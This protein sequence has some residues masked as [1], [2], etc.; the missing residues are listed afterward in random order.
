MTS[1][2]QHPP[3]S[4]LMEQWHRDIS[5]LLDRTSEASRPG[6]S[7]DAAWAPDVDLQDRVPEQ[8]LVAAKPIP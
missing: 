2:A 4:S 1:P 8:S 3:W 5:Q 7:D 6:L